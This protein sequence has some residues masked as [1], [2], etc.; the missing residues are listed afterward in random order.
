M[1]EQISILADEHFAWLK[2]VLERTALIDKS[3]MDNE[4]V[5][6][7]VEYIY[8]TAFIHG[9]KHAIEL[10]Q[11][12]QKMLEDHKHIEDYKH[13]EERSD[14]AKLFGDSSSGTEGH[15]SL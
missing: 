14:R 7:L 11:E 10:F 15:F 8:K 1:E 5:L 3:F 12:S 13:I 9:G 2:G 6:S 4:R